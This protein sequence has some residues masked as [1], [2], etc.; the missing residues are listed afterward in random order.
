[1][2]E[3][4][5]PLPIMTTLAC[6]C[7]NEPPLFA[8]LAQPL[9]ERRFLD[10]LQEAIQVMMG[11]CLIV[12]IQF[13]DAELQEAPERLA[14]VGGQAHEVQVREMRCGRLTEIV[15]QEQLASFGVERLVDGE[16]AQVEE[17]V[18]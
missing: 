8:N 6:S 18:A 9:Y 12:E 10:V 15:G 2:L 13:G 7:M 1:M 16:I 4:A 3:P 17:Q 5:I 11:V 14:Q